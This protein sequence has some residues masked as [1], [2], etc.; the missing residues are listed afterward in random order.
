MSLITSNAV[1]SASAKKSGAADTT[2]T[3]SQSTATLSKISPALA[4]AHER[5]AAQ[6]QTESTSISQLGQYKA[7]VSSL[8]GAASTLAGVSAG[9]SLADIAKLADS[10]VSA[11]N[12]AIKQGNAGSGGS[13]GGQSEASRAVTESRKSLT[14]SDSSR[15][16]LSKLGFARQ[17]DGTLKLDVDALKKSLSTDLAGTT[18]TL[19]QMGK[20][21]AKRADA[22]LTDKGR[23]TTAKEKASNRALSLMQQQSSLLDAAA[24]LQ[25]AQANTGSWAARQAVQKYAAS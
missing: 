8:S 7:A 4:K 24:Q 5:L 3:Q 9:S 11:F 14:S 13:V 16:Q 22:E 15:S 10:Y 19:S 6:Y 23:L 18:V 1:A 2:V 12:A 17:A 20:A 21:I 25:Q